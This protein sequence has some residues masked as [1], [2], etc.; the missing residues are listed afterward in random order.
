[1]PFMTKIHLR[2]E[3][4]KFAAAHM[5]VF[6]DGTKEALHGHNYSTEISVVLADTSLKGM[7][8]FSVFKENVRKICEAWDE[9]VLIAA[10]CPF[11][12]VHSKTEQETEF[13]L[14]GKRYVLPSDEVV[15]LPVENITS[16]SLSEIFFNQFVEKI[17]GQWIPNPIQEIHVRI[18][19]SPG[20]GA[21]YSRKLL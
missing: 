2:K 9:K 15:F 12:K 4:L 1:M 20:Q 5:T 21:T 7:I 14:C 10:K 6:A 18:D 17:P 3:G 8:P 11:L 13:V 19:E 16:E